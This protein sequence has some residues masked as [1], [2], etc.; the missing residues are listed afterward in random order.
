MLQQFIHKLY[1]RFLYS[2]DN[3]DK[4]PQKKQLLAVIFFCILLIVVL[5]L[6]SFFY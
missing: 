6:F 4:I 3:I 2:A 5:G 1:D